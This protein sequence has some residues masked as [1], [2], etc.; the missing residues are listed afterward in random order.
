[1]KT[2]AL[3]GLLLASAAA[4]GMLG[5]P[6]CSPMQSEIRYRQFLGPIAS[7]AGPE[8]ISI[9]CQLTTESGAA[10]LPGPKFELLSKAGAILIESDADGRIALPR[11]P[12]ILQENPPLRKL[13]SGKLHYEIKFTGAVAGRNGKAL[14]MSVQGKP[15]MEV[16]R[17]R[18]WYPP[19][20]EETARAL[21]SALQSQAQCIHRLLG[22][23]PVPWAIDLISA[24]PAGTDMMTA[25]DQPGWSIWTYATG[26]VQSGEYVAINVHEWT[27]AT[28]DH[29]LDL[30]GA[31]GSGRNRVW[32]D[33][34]AEYVATQ[35]QGKQPP[36]YAFALYD[37][38][39]RGATHVDLTEAFRSL[40][41]RTRPGES[42]R[43]L[44][45]RKVFPAGY[46]L[47]FAF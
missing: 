21:L 30:A 14:L 37:L 15:H 31:D 18:V 9:P 44:I 43:Q 40:R 32:T 3:S 19:G 7:M 29:H 1:M 6:G 23:S 17:V 4:L 47:S 20:E 13:Y 38:I 24:P 2:S 41:G 39:A 25:Q 46:P 33:G 42:L 27:E 16:D 35:Y 5:L 12:E 34:L 11:R 45:D 22:L 28:L 26:R 10:P 36:D 8:S